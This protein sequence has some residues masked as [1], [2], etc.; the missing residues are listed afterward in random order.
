MTAFTAS[1]TNGS[2]LFA[3]EE[4]K[5]IFEGEEFDLIIFS[6][7]PRYNIDQI[8]PLIRRVFGSINYFA[9]NAT[10]AFCDE[11]IIDQ[12]IVALGIRFNNQRSRFELF[13]QESLDE[14][15]LQNT[16]TYLNKNQDAFHVLIATYADGAFAPFLNALSQ[17]LT[18]KVDNIIGGISSGEVV[19]GE[20][21]TFVY[22]EDKIIKTGFV[23]LSFY[24]IQNAMEISL[25][26]KPYGITYTITQ[27]ENAHLYKVDDQLDFSNIVKDFLKGIP[28]PQSQYLWYAPIWILENDGYVATLRTIEEIGEGYVKFFGPLQEGEQFKI[29]FGT[30]ETILEANKEAAKN[31]LQK[32]SQM[33]LVFN[34]SC[35]AREY[36]LDEKRSEEIGLYTSILN[37]HLFG[38]FTF[39]EI[40]PNKRFSKLKLYNETSL[41]VGLKE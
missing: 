7:H 40:G 23:I 5:S 3:L 31:L 39:G 35:I 34:F 17:R 20:L 37:A 22:L 4:I 13:F 36:I 11:K 18:Y 24:N 25:G 27:A 12:G 2:L 21:R 16:A 19:E 15:A 8:N 33:D 41:I 26:F 6:I 32:L 9:F 1:S 38:F 29:S 14:Q 28:N 30:A 10:S